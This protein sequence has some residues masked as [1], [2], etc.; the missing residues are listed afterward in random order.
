MKKIM[1]LFA[2]LMMCGSLWSQEVF[3]V[4]YATSDDGFVNVRQRPSA[5]SK[6]NRTN[7]DVISWFGARRLARTTR[8]L[9]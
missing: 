2:A 4:V 7:L 3:T 8:K 1:M 6:K 9:G 5:K